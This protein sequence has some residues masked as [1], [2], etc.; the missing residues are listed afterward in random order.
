MGTPLGFRLGRA[1]RRLRLAVRALAT[2]RRWELRSAFAA[3]PGVPQEASAAGLGAVVV[4]PAVAWDYRWQ[5]PQQLAVALAAAGRPVVYVDPFARSRLSPRLVARQLG[6]AFLWL[7][8]AL[9]GLPD[10][11][12]STLD[13]A[14]AERLADE[15]LASLAEPPDWLLVQ[16]PFWEPLAGALAA[17]TGA[18]I[19]YDRLDLHAGFASIPASVLAAEERLLD[20]AHLVVATSAALAETRRPPAGRIAL[21]RNGVDLERFRL[22]PPP[23][24]GRPRVGFVGALAAWVDAAGLAAAARARPGLDFLIAGRV[25]DAGF[26]ALER[27]PNVQ[28]LGEV[29]HA[30]VPR[31]L[32]RLDAA[33]VPFRDLPLTRAV[34]PVKLYEAL[35]VGLP[36]VARRLPEIARWAGTVE[37]YDA[38]EELPAAL[39]RA[40]AAGGVEARAARRAAV[41]GES[42]VERAVTLERLVAP[43]VRSPH[44]AAP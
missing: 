16:L 8:L 9:R 38:S 28:L 23:V 36:V 1:E 32:A 26:R 37:L 40:L 43:L 30:E 15:L 6:P 39:D 10:P 44:P 5:R 13:P 29:P 7:L 22:A 21:V 31:F 4:L 25:E 35:A 17:R 27:E 18:P 2:R 19:V 41:A 34:D 3:V 12:R 20:R 33:L 14:E 11:Y 42:W 24:G